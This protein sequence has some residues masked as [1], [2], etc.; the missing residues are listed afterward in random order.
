MTELDPSPALEEALLRIFVA[1]QRRDEQLPIVVRAAR[2]TRSRPTA[3]ARRWIGVIDATRRRH[4]AIASLAARR[5]LQPLRPTAHRSGPNRGLGDD[6]GARRR[7]C[8]DAT[9]ARSEQMDRLVDC[10]LPLS[11]ILAEENLLAGTRLA[12][13]AAR[14]ADP[15]VLQDPR[16]GVGAGRAGAGRTTC[17]GPST[18]TTAAPCTSSRCG[19]PRTDVAE[20]LDVAA[21]VAAAVAAPDT[22]DRRRVPAAAPAST[23]VTTDALAAQVRGPA[24]RRRRCPSS[25]RRVA[26]IPS[27]ADVDLLTFRRA[28]VDGARPYWMALGARSRRRFAE[29]I[30]FRGLH[31]MIARRLQMWRLKNFE[32]RP[33]PRARRGP[34][35]RLR[36]PGH[37]VRRAAH[38]RRRGPRPDAR[39][40]TTTGRVV[41]LPEV[42]HVLVGCLDAIRQARSELPGAHRLEW[43]RV[44][45]YIWPVVDLPLDDVDRAWPAGWR[46]SPRASGSSRSS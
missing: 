27:G 11:P 4:P 23:T 12:G 33:P 19:P 15:P 18:S 21:E 14:G 22:V 37:P 13:S 44:M 31:P 34:P 7:P 5:A 16:A 17:A 46:P 40:A 9:D 41:A 45:L 32:I 28:D 39:C 10:A 20:A 25:I 35:L 8:S 26:V 2:G 24:R 3:C 43:N 6:E 42:E 1:Q 29:D 36:R 30:K 38:R